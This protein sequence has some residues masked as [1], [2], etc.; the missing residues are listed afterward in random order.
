VIGGLAG[1]AGR[2]VDLPC[3][4]R[5][6]LGL[7]LGA[8]AA[9]AVLGL[10]VTYPAAV[11]VAPTRELAESLEPDQWE[12]DA[13]EHLRRASRARVRM[14]ETTRRV[15]RL[16]VRLLRI[17]VWSAGAGIVLL[18]AAVIIALAVG[19]KPSP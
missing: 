15:N 1:I 14:I 10:A 16:K 7:A 5:V 6:L 9:G 12:A 19:P 13:D 4:T 18:L 11:L 3:A 2:G 8:L 17:G